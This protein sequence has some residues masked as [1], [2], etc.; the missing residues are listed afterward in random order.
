VW[1]DDGVIGSLSVEQLDRVLTPK[2]DAAW[3]LHE[4]T[5][6]TGLSL[7]VVFSS[8]AGVLGGPGLGNYAAGNVFLDALMQQRRHLGLTGVSMAWGPWTAE[9]GL[10]GS[11]SEIDLRRFARSGLPMLSVRQGLELFDRALRTDRAVLGLTRLDLATLRA[12]HDVPHM[13]RTL[14]GSPT[15]RTAYDSRRSSDG[16]AQRLAGM[17]AAERDRFLVDLV[18]GNAAVVLGYVLRQADHR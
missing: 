1:P 5:Q 2:V 4:L 7:F 11:L 16:L 6:K 15:R 3:H 8:V 17:S 10:A 12:Q 13:W 18:R 14:A 9:V